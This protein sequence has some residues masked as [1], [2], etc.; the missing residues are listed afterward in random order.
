MIEDIFVAFEVLL[1]RR[2]NNVAENELLEGMDIRS[3]PRNLESWIVADPAHICVCT[4][5]HLEA[6]MT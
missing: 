6:A 5:S 3:F 4:N 2:K 1:N